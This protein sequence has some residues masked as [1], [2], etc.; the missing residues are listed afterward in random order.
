MLQ[1]LVKKG[2]V[3]TPHADYCLPGI[4][5]RTVMELVVKEKMVLSERRISIS[6]FHT[7]DELVL[8][9]YTYSS[10]PPFYSMFHYVNCFTA[11]DHNRNHG[12]THSKAEKEWKLAQSNMESSSSG[13]VFAANELSIA[14]INS[15]SALAL[16][17]A[18]S[19][20]G[21]ITS[22]L[23]GHEGASLLA[24]LGALSLERISLRK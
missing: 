18:S 6:E 11:G 24:V 9:N 5:R 2:H 3:A 13:L 17:A 8:D 15:K 1:N 10:I 12:R 7:A 23:A 4:T 22:A 20:L 19:P 14:S 16:V 21:V